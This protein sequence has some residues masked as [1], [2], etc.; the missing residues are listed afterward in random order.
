MPFTGVV[1][2]RGDA[3]WETSAWIEAVE[4]WCKGYQECNA[5]LDDLLLSAALLQRTGKLPSSIIEISSNNS[6]L[7]V[8]T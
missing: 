6:L 5:L 3:L 4:F 1:P 7:Q 8:S 2:S